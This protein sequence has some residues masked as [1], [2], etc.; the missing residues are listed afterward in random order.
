MVY[1]RFKRQRWLIGNYC[2]LTQLT[3][4]TQATESCQPSL[5]CSKLFCR[6]D[7]RRNRIEE[8]SWITKITFIEGRQI[9]C[10]ST[11]T[12]LETDLVLGYAVTSLKKYNS[13]CL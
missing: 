8:A 6:A 1:D 2:G 7:T 11:S 4:S 9:T 5:L 10:S 13:E 3:L 12:M